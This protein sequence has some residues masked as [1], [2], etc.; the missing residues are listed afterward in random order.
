MVKRYENPSQ[1]DQCSDGVNWKGEQSDIDEIRNEDV[2]VLPKLT[3]R[4]FD[5]LMLKLVPL[6]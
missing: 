3:E 4:S 1:A 5:H 2:R 6:M